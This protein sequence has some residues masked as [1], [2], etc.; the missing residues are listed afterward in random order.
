M[1]MRPDCSPSKLILTAV[2]CVLL[3]APS[4]PAQAAKART[5]QVRISYGPPQ[6]P[7]HQA[8]LE[9]L[10]EIR[11]LEDLRRFLSPIRLPRTVLVKTESCN[12]DANAW[13]D[14][15]EITICYDYIAE[16]WRN[17]PAETTKEGVTPIDAIVAPVFDTVLHEFA[18]AIFEI[19]KLPVFGREEDAA[20]QV[21]AYIALQLG[22]DEARRQIGGI[23]YAFMTEATTAAAPPR[24]QDFASVHGTP[25]QR[26]YNVLC[27]AYGAD[28]GSFGKYVTQGHLPLGRAMNCASEYRQAA[29]AF[30][31]LIAPHVDQRLARKILKRSWLPDP[32]GPLPETPPR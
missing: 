23:A 7:A 19:L 30:D 28:P 17:A 27:I 32:E 1:R 16:M 9:R 14:A 21:A 15:G 20:D 3:L 5:N 8:I 13:Y 29:R 24:L 10:K 31:T 11:A 6:N 12:G 4:A 2:T 26:F 18:H 22:K 25:A